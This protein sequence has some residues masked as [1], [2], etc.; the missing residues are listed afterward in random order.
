MKRRMGRD[1]RKWRK[2]KDLEEIG[3]GPIQ[4]IVHPYGCFRISSCIKM[5]FNSHEAF[6]EASE[7]EETVAS[8]ENSKIWKKSAVSQFKLLS[9]RMDVLEYRVV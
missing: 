8:G 6:R 3:G 9:T 1:V 7:W 4:V 2:C 5:V